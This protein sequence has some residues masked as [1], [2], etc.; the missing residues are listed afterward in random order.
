MIDFV[1]LFADRDAGN[2][3]W[4]ICVRSDSETADTRH[5]WALVPDRASA[6]RITGVR[7]VLAIPSFAQ[8][9]GDPVEGK[10]AIHWTN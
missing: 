2:F 8:W 9:P 3:V 10:L 1:S 4:K 5:G 6:V 7:D